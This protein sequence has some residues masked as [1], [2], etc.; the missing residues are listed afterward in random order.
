MADTSLVQFARL[1]GSDSVLG[2]AQKVGL[3]LPLPPISVR[4]VIDLA[5]RLPPPPVHG[6]YCEFEDPPG[7]IA[8]APNAY[9][10]IDG[11]PRKSQLSWS[12]SGNV[13]GVANMGTVLSAAF[14]KW[15]V[16]SKGHLNFTQVLSG[17]DISLGVQ[18]LGGPNPATGFLTLGRTIGQSISFNNNPAAVFVPQGGNPSLLGVATHEIGH[19]LGLLH[20][21]NP[22]AIILLPIR[23]TR[24][25]LRKTLR[26]SSH[27]TGG[28]RRRPL[29]EEERNP[30]PR[31]ARAGQ[32]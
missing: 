32:F 22:A 2:M 13:N 21:T 8:V 27:C 19:A 24:T 1:L 28:I 6:L 10:L 25:S 9:G 26:P 20:S 4:N 18:D 12:V 14:A 23:L 15:R 29:R 7:S 30:V 17:A 5:R 11:F 16:A 3:T 31:S